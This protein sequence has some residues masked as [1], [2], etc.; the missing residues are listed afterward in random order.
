M[1]PLVLNTITYPE[2][3]YLPLFYILSPIPKYH[4]SPCTTFYPLYPGFLSPL[5]LHTIHHPQVSCHLL[6]YILYTIARYHESPRTTHKLIIQYPQSSCLPL[7]HRYHVYP[8]T[9]YYHPLSPLYYILSYT[10]PL[11]LHT[12]IHYP[13]CTTYQ[14]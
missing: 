1:S 14:G 11:V 8:C 7:Y 2:V 3:S 13:P 10:I 9:T 12:I 4:D 5:V 6:Y